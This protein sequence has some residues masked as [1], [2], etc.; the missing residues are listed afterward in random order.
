[1]HP[2]LQFYVD[3][4]NLLTT[5]RQVVQGGIGRIP[6]SEI[7]RFCEDENIVGEMRDDL[8]YLIRQMD[9]FYVKW[10]SDYISKK[11]EANSKAAKN[12]VNASKPRRR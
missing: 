10:Q 1:M 8:F 2:G 11:L 12:K 4:F 5:S 9:D 3:A 7:S 6:Y